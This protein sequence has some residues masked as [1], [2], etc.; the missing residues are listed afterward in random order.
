M[1][2]RGS[3]RSPVP[4]GG[5]NEQQARMP[6]LQGSQATLAD[7]SKAIYPGQGPCRIGRVIKRVVDGRLLIFYHLFVLD[8]SGS[9]LFIPV[10]KARAIGLRL[11]IEKSQIPTLLTHLQ[12]S[13]AT[14]DNWK[15]RAKDN[16]RLFA[17]GSPF[18]LAEIVA[19]LT[20]LSDSRSLTLG[21][22]MI[23][24]KARKLLVCEISEVSGE[25]KTTAEEQ[26]DRALNANPGISRPINSPRGEFERNR[27]ARRKLQLVR[28]TTPNHP[29]SKSICS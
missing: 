25:T 7:G 6:E 18:D 8:E 16:A 26:L 24:G 10:E 23:L 9:E 21:E 4:S 11:L 22:T 13:A 29:G 14:A 5:P 15:Q 19:S 27:G 1:S 20:E 28:S 17:S 3:D 12:K 2:A